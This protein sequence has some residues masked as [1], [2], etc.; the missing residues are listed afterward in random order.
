[1]TELLDIENVT[2]RFDGLVALKDVGLV[3]EA[4]T[5]LG[6]IGPNGAGKTT[7]FNVVC[8][9]IR[10]QHGMIRWCG[11]ELRDHQPHALAGLGIARTLQ[12]LG[13]FP[14]M[15][16]LDNVLVGAGRL[17]RS[18]PVSTLLGLR[19]AAKD[20]A[21]LRARAVS[22][23]D[24]LGIGDTHAAYPGSLPYGIRKRVALARALV[25]EP[26]LLMLDEPASGLAADE[27][28]EL[29]E[30]ITGL[31]ARSAVVVVEHNMDLVM[32]VCDRIVVL[33]FGEV[34]ATGTPAEIQSDPRV[35]EAY[36]GVPA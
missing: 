30:R 28:D 32:R 25:A 21:E 31:A 20:E 17:A 7:L 29:G 13:L 14:A 11:T 8:G 12:G 27:I 1:M 2:V 23:L 24:E 10:P 36:L 34:I 5:V 26:R 16:V 22:T 18:G 6:V 3:V 33:D 4:G 9:F 19:R 15:S 35:V